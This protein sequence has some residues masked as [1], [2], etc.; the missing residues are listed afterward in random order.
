MWS[1]FT[2]SDVPYVKENQMISIE[3]C[4]RAHRQNK[5]FLAD[6]WHSVRLGMN[7]L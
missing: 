5:I 3:E 4:V 7:T 1:H 6:E 2:W